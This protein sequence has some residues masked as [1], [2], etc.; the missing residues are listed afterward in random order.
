MSAIEEVVADG[1]VRTRAPS[2][3]GD[4]QTRMRTRPN[5]EGLDAVYDRL[6]LHVFRLSVWNVTAIQLYELA[7]SRSA[8]WFRQYLPF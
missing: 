3:R 8:C 7:I 4:L 5:R 6:S 2:N 1:Q